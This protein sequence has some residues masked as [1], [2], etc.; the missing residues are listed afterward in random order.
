MATSKLNAQ[1]PR[2]AADDPRDPPD[3]KGRTGRQPAPAP[4]PAR[5]AVQLDI[6]PSPDAGEAI[7]LRQQ[8]TQIVIVDKASHTRALEFTR[9]AKQLKRKIEDHWMRITRN[10]DDL[11]RNLLDLKRAD[12]EPVEAALAQIDGRIVDYVNTEQRRQREEEDRQRRANEEQARRDRDAELARQE[13]EALDLEAQSPKLSMRERT[14]VDMVARG[15]EPLKVARIA[16][17]KNPSEAAEK[18][19]ATPKIVDAIATAKTAME[20]REQAD[21]LARQPI[22]A[23]APHVESKL[24]R[25]AGTRL[26]TSYSCE[27]D[28]DLDALFEAA[29]LNPDLRRAFSA[30][31]VYLNQQARALRE[32][33]ESVFPG[34][35]LHK[36]TTVAG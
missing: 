14:F 2:H 11:K 5:P 31:T 7:T 18:L 15:S 13:Q 17:Y 10:V 3:V 29:I 23:P 26:V 6:Q 12:L 19:M 27:P 30:N 35:R 36:S 32:S 24:G 25:A 33:F 22:S 28:V 1:R 8:A 4:P 9:G 16:G 21:A 34:C 20:I